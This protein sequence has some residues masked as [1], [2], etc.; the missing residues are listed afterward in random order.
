MSSYCFC[1]HSVDFV[2]VAA[3][4]LVRTGEIVESSLAE[5]I[6]DNKSIEYSFFSGAGTGNE[7]MPATNKVPTRLVSNDPYPNPSIRSSAAVVPLLTVQS[8]FHATQA[9]AIEMS[10]LRMAMSSSK[11]GII[12]VIIR[13]HPECIL[14]Q[15][16]ITSEEETKQRIESERKK[17][18]K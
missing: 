15:T 18:K 5:N 8:F 13:T 14:T 9:R 6:E 16:V 10:S 3:V 7:V 11:C 12:I 2:A 17:K 1:W 4:V